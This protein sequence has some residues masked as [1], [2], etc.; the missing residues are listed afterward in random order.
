MVKIRCSKLARQDD[1]KEGFR[2][3]FFVVRKHQNDVLDLL[4]QFNF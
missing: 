1:V 4:I 3:I 2:D